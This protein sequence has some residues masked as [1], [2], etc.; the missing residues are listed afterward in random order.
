[1]HY[2]NADLNAVEEEGES[3]FYTGMGDTGTN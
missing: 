1:M 3:D 2:D